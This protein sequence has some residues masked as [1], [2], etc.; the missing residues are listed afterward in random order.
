MDIVLIHY[1]Y[2]FLMA[3][4]RGRSIVR[5]LLTARA[6]ME[7]PGKDPLCLI[8]DNHEFDCFWP[9]HSSARD[10]S[11]TSFVASNRTLL[12][13]RSAIRTSSHGSIPPTRYGI[14][15]KSPLSSSKRPLSES[16]TYTRLP[17]TSG[18]WN[19]SATPVGTLETI[20][21]T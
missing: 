20:F 11:C 13:H 3:R 5:P 18:L 4:F 2:P 19:L 15:C 21:A 7:E 10:D 14:R 9:R 6:R 8:H 1:R 12:I 16:S 17:N